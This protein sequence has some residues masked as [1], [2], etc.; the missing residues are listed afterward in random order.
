MSARMRRFRCAAASAAPGACTRM[1][2][3]TAPRSARPFDV[4]LFGATGYTGRLVAERLARAS[5]AHP[6]RWALAGRDKAKLEKVREELAAQ[7]PAAKDLALLVGDAH[8]DAAMKKIAAQARCVCTTVGPYLKYGAGVVAA[9][10]A[11][12]TDYCDL[13][14]ETP[15]IR[16]MIDAHHE[17]AQKTGARIVHCCGFDSIPADLG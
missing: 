4:V 2:P 7:V 11:E 17:E 1:R 12:G 6:L 5:V 9:C 14:G 10:A 15:F 8:D 16:A 13:T 3:M